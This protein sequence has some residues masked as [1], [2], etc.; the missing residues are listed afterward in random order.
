MSRT[1]GF[2]ADVAAATGPWYSVRLSGVLRAIA[3]LATLTAV[4]AVP[5]LI[6][7]YRGRVIGWVMSAVFH[8][9]GGDGRKQTPGGEAVAN[10][11]R[12]HHYGFFLLNYANSGGEQSNWKTAVAALC[13]TF[14]QLTAIVA[15]HRGYSA[16]AEWLTKYSYHSVYDPRFQSRY[17]AYMSCFDSANYYSSLV[18]I[19]F[20]KVHKTLTF[21]RLI[22]TA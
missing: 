9:S 21:R 1:G 4:A 2:Q 20:F 17:T 16:V 19:A 11:R 3:F 12:G 22:T 6:V 8:Q 5:V 14:V 7:V 10:E 15:V 18:Y 13:A